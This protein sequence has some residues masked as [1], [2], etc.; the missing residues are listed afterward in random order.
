[1]RFRLRFVLV[2]LPLL[3]TTAVPMSALAQEQIQTREEW[4]AAY[5]NIGVAGT[6]TYPFQEFGDDYET[7]YGLHLL[8]DYPLIPLVNFCGNAG[9]T[10]FGHLQSGEDINVLS[11][12]FGA[13]VVFGPVFMGG[14]TGYYSEIKEWGWVPSFGLRPGNWELSLRYKS[15]GAG[16]WT[17]LRAGYYF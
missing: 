13:K 11:V 14:E 2:L 4:V 1:M 12:V 3:L 8:L 9:F 17:T 6:L 16:N 5:R 10:H 7:G 15:A